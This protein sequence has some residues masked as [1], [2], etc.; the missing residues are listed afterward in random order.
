LEYKSSFSF[1]FQQKTAMIN[2]KRISQLAKKS[3]RMAALG[4]KRLAMKSSKEAEGCSTAVAGKGHYVMYTADGRRFEVPLGYLGKTVFSEL[5]RISEEFGFT[6]DDGRITLPYDATVMEYILCLLRRNASIEVENAFL[7]SMAIPYDYTGSIYSGSSLLQTS[8]LAASRT[9]HCK[10]KSE[11]SSFPREKE[12]PTM[13]SARRIAQLAKWQRMAALG[14][15]RLNWGLQRKML[16]VA[17]LWQA[18]A[19]TS[20]AEFGFTRDGRITLP[21][22]AAVMEYAICLLRGNASAEIEKAFMSTMAVSCCHYESAAPSVG[23]EVA[24]C[25]S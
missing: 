11:L 1:H 12:E 5:L 4:R 19:T 22:D 7:S 8:S 25:S 16:S 3:Q 24:V 13:I 14:R 17:L 18:K 15:K 6:S 21:C 9:K 2:A 10:L 20:Q 23:V